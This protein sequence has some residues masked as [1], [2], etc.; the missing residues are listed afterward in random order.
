MKLSCEINSPIVCRSLTPKASIT[1][2]TSRKNLSYF[3]Q[4]IPHNFAV[5]NS[6]LQ[7]SKELATIHRQ[8][9]SSKP[10]R[11]KFRQTN[12]D[13]GNLTTDSPDKDSDSEILEPKLEQ[14]PVIHTQK[15]REDIKAHIRKAQIQ[16][17]STKHTKKKIKIKP[18]PSWQRHQLFS[19]KNRTESHIPTAIRSFESY[20]ISSERKEAMKKYDL[21]SLR[22]QN[23]YL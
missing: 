4:Y 10:R 19:A 7:A 14:I 23:S 2:A 16:T 8:L 5:S 17:Q 9:F 20:S 13:Q 12:C 18:M 21:S 6:I 11:L 22:I 3:R 15:S 1:T